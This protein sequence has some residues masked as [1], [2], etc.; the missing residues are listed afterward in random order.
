MTPICRFGRSE[1][2][3]PSVQD[4]LSVDCEVVVSC[5]RQT[6]GPR[7]SGRPFQ[8]ETKMNRSMTLSR[9]VLVGFAI[10]L[11]GC[12]GS[13]PVPNS[14]GGAGGNSGGGNSSGGGGG[15][16]AG[17]MGGGTVAAKTGFQVTVT[18]E[19]FATE[20]IAFP[21][22]AGSEEPFFQDGWEVKFESIVA[23]IDNVAVSENPDKSPNDQS[24]TDGL[25]AELKGPWVVDLAKEGPLTA[26][27]MN[28]KAFVLGAIENQNKKGGAAFDLTKKYA[29]GFDTIKA[30]AA[31][32]KVNA[33]DDSVISTMVTKGYSVWVKGTAEFKGTNCRSTVASYDFKRLP[34]KVNFAFGFAAPTTYI[35]CNNPELMPANSR[36]ISPKAGDVVVAQTTLHFDHPFWEALIED[37]P[38]R[39]D[40]IAA[41]KSVATGEGPAMVSMTDADLVGVAFDDGKDAQGTSLP[42]R[43][44]GPVV[45]SERKAGTVNYDTNGV[46]VN[47]LGGDKGLKDLLDYSTYNLS[48]YGHLNNDGLCYPKRNFPAPP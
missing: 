19:G 24:M 39:F 21:A 22:P 45:A 31:A 5:L 36:G 2:N 20:G 8:K 43:Y 1:P 32:T 6:T 4:V 26:K 33:V 10:L 12:P 18:G 3:N 44:C 48:T 29:F 11:C 13:D 7:T 16:A 27:E 37:A 38:L 25:V 14:G 15:A 28:G 47:P 17:G 35:N 30:V 34:K 40:L 23:F 41:R 46:P 42:W 9:A